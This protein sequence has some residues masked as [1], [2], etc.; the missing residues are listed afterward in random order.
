MPLSWPRPFLSQLGWLPHTPSC[1]VFSLLLPSLGSRRPRVSPESLPQLFSSHQSWALLPGPL[2][3]S[4]Q[5]LLHMYTPTTGGC[6][7]LM[8]LWGQSLHWA[9]LT[10]L[11][12]YWKYEN[13]RFSPLKAYLWSL[14]QLPSHSPWFCGCFLLFAFNKYLSTVYIFVYDLTSPT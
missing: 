12:Q 9:L 10:F 2:W 4:K 8:C 3:A 1:V 13:S 11:S 6:F 14:V 5:A 7:S